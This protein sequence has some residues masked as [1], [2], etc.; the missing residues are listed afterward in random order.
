MPR[1]VARSA[2]L[3]DEGN[4]HFKKDDYIGAESLYSKAYVF[5]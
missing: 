2:A 5:G 4:V 3:K 1:D